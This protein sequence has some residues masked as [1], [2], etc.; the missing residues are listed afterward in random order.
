LTAPEGTVLGITAL[1]VIIGVASTAGDRIV[2]RFDAL[3]ATSVTQERNRDRADFVFLGD[4]PARKA[5]FPCAV[6]DEDREGRPGAGVRRD[7]TAW[8]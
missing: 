6:E 7:D 2:G 8:L 3:T 1:V 4:R 5:L